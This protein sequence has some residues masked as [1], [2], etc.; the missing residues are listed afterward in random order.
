MMEAALPRDIAKQDCMIG[1]GR[2]NALRSAEEISAIP[3]QAAPLQRPPMKTT[4]QKF[5]GTINIEP[6]NFAK[7]GKQSV[8]Y[9]P[10]GAGTNQKQLVSL[11][12]PT[13][14]L[15]RQCKF[16]WRPKRIMRHK[17][18]QVPMHATRNFEQARFKCGAFDAA[19]QRHSERERDP[20]GEDFP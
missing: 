15:I 13:R 3:C 9:A 8:G 2:Q 18:T 20:E 17:R 6:V 7:A 10:T 14:Q 12:V 5:C 4:K 16:E 1:K 19:A 11:R